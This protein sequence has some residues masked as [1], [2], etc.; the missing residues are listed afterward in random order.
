MHDPIP[1][2]FY[3]ESWEDADHPMAC[4]TPDN[5]FRR[6]NAAFERLLGYSSPELEGR[7]WEEFTSQTHVG[8][9]LAS[10]QAVLDGRIESYRLEKDYIH[11][12][13]HR[14]PIVL[15]V[16]RY[17]RASTQTLLYFR[18]EAPLAMAT[19]PEVDEIEK[20]AMEAIQ[21]LKNQLDELR[22]S[23]VSVNVGNQIKGNN[24]VGGNS[25]S[26]QMIKYL[27]GGM[28]AITV[29]VA[30]MFYYIATSVNQTPPEKP[31]VQIP[32]E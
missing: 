3:R 25:N 23:G 11:K 30:W 27:V 14:V 17:P 32:S 2:A 9:D 31:N 4:V 10:V 19:R 12:R 21:T 29:M 13:G 6:V 22:N 8:G 18:V 28:V 7:K 20:H 15:H 5:K 24:N 16:R 1:D 26:D